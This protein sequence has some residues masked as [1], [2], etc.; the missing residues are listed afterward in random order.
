MVTKYKHV[1]SGRKVSVFPI[2]LVRVCVHQENF[3]VLVATGELLLHVCVQALQKAFL[4][5]SKPMAYWNFM[6]RYHTTRT[7]LHIIYMLMIYMTAI[8]S[9]Y[10]GMYMIVILTCNYIKLTR[11]TLNCFVFSLERDFQR[12]LGRP[13]FQKNPS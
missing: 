12:I 7:C 1:Y 10:S 2:L 3:E 13:P 5:L 11:T 8:S 6:V 4:N 9:C